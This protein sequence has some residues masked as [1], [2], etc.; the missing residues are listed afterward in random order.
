MIMLAHVDG[1]CDYV[2]VKDK[3]KSKFVVKF[4]HITILYLIK[5]I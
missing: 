2:F 3:M 5:I 4:L 1:S